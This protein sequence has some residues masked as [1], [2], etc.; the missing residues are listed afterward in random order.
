MGFWLIAAAV[1]GFIGVAMGAFAAHGLPA[2]AASQL[3]GWVETGARYE[4]WHALALLAIA[5]LV[6]VDGAGAGRRWLDLAGWAFLIGMILFSGSLYLMALTRLPFFALIT[7]L[8]GIA[9]LVGW[10]ALCLY[11]LRRGAA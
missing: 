7:P 10:V 6:R 1:N 2:A 8:G 9:F 4:M 5:L 3:P 11:G